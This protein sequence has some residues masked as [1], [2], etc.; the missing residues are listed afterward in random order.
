MKT[1]NLKQENHSDIHTV[2]YNELTYRGKKITDLSQNELYE[3]IQW[4]YNDN[5]KYR[6]M[7]FSSQKDICD[8]MQVAIDAKRSL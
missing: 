2:S 8:Y 5:K 3:A 4:L 7:Y 1:N 6:D